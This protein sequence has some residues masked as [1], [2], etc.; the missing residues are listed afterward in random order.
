MDKLTKELA[1]AIIKHFEGFRQKPYLC[2]A[3][4]PT[5]GWGQTFYANGTRVTLNDKPIDQTLADK[6]LEIEV[7]R[8]YDNISRRYVKVPL[9]A[10]K[11]AAIIQ[12]CYNLGL[13]NFQQ[14]TLRSVIN[15]GD[16][17]QVPKQLARWNKANGK[18]LRGLTLRRTAEIEL[19]LADEE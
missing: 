15:Q 10:N 1:C 13:G 9:S 14:S 5:I 4:V 11:M 18:A 2:S 3:G 19:W 12:F 17:D 8:L 16:F 7:E 6:L